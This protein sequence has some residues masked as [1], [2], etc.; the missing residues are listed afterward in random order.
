MT[1]RL[2][3]HLMLTEIHRLSGFIWV[4]CDVMGSEHTI[5]CTFPIPYK[6]R[7]VDTWFLTHSGLLWYGG[8]HGRIQNHSVSTLVYG[9]GN[10]VVKE[11]QNRCHGTASMQNTSTC[12]CVECY[13]WPLVPYYSF[14]TILV[15][16]QLYCVFIFIVFSCAV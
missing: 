1:V 7:H 9:N 10:F 6:S 8:F 13:S 4:V 11:A 2:G 5:V 15:T 3:S 12:K 16:S 14:G